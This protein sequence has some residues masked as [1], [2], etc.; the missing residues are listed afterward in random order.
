MIRQART[1]DIES[2][3]VI[4]N[5]AKKMIRQTG[6][7]QWQ[8]GYP[9]EDTFKQDILNKQLYVFVSIEGLVVGVMA[10]MDYEQ[11]YD[12]IKG[13][14]LN[15]RPYKVIHRIAVKSS[16]LNQN[17]AKDMINFVFQS[18]RTK[19]IRIDTHENNARMIRF[20]EKEH[21][22]NCGT[23]YLAQISDR[24]RMAFHKAI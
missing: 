6:S 22:I 17:I 18:L 14:W 23:I 4:I 19:D 8:N 2:I 20:L 7:P 3:M 13:N 10:V 1:E 21:F 5:Q 16:H 9:N 15:D 24:I 12:D 11:T